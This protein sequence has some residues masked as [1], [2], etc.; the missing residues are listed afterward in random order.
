[1]RV[2][3]IIAIFFISECFAH[4]T[5]KAY[6]S[7][8]E[9][10]E[11]TEVIAEFPWTIRKSV[12]KFAPELENSKS[13]KEFQNAF[14]KYLSANLLLKDAQNNLLELVSVEKVELE[15]HS[16]QNDYKL[17]FEGNNVTSITNTILFNIN[18]TQ[19]NFHTWKTNNENLKFITNIENNTFSYQSTKSY[20]LS[21][22]WLFAILP[23]LYFIPKKLSTR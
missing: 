5:N 9:N 2:V 6:F 4:D 21:Y 18:S 23:I 15:R 3:V 7:I 1:M 22:L 16:H 11:T 12:L 10:D 14:K 19:E 17:I 20:S 13:A 8:S